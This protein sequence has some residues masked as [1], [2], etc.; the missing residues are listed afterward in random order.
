[1]QKYLYSLLDPNN[2]AIIYVWQTY[3]FKKN[4]VTRKLQIYQDVLRGVAAIDV[5]RNFWN[6]FS[7]L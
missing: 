6:R 4:G 1:M 3:N 2:Q 7:K 5:C